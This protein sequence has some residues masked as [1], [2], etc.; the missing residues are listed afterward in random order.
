MSHETKTFNKRQ[1]PLTVRFYVEHEVIIVYNT[2]I[3][4]IFHF[5][6]FV[7][8]NAR[9]QKKYLKIDKIITDIQQY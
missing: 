6:F 5:P 3:A 7:K 4:V 2:P 1:N 9:K 8:Q